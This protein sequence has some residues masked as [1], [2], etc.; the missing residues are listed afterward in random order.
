[1]LLLL[2]FLSGGMAHAQ[3]VIDVAVFYT[4][5]AKTAQGGTAQVETKIDEL[6]AATN[7]AYTSGGVNQRINL[8]HVEEVNT[9]RRRA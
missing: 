8:V 6:V 7:M 9:R 4:T 5:A 3:S 1:M 2:S